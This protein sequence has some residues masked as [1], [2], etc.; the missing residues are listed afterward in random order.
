MHQL[1]WIRSCKFKK[2]EMCWWVIPHV[3]S[4]NRPWECFNEGVFVV[5]FHTCATMRQLICDYYYYVDDC[6]FCSEQTRVIKQFVR[7]SRLNR[8][9]LDLYPVSVERLSLEEPREYWWPRLQH[10]HHH[11]RWQA[12][13]LRPGAL[14]VLL[15]VPLPAAH[16]QH[17]HEKVCALFFFV[18]QTF[19]W[20]RVMRCRSD[21]RFGK[22]TVLWKH[23]F[24]KEICEISDL[25]M[26]EEFISWQKIW[27]K[28]KQLFTH[29]THPVRD[30]LE[31]PGIEN[32]AVVFWN[33]NWMKK[34]GRE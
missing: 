3:Q 18:Q 29:G 33:M 12:A 14:Q 20:A 9:W 13:A 17:A 19:C 6:R 32:R 23:L 7:P 5:L 24:I 22:T 10:L 30:F 21:E 27:L 11:Q 31:L 25:F 26:N 34:N 1:H 8:N 4:P 15:P 2:R 16:P 28:E